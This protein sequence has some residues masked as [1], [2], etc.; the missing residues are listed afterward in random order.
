M[1]QEI[2]NPA[3]SCITYFLMYL[4]Q[5]WINDNFS[6][7]VPKIK[8][9]RYY[10]VVS[11]CRAN[12][13]KTCYTLILVLSYLIESGLLLWEIVSYRLEQILGFVFIYLL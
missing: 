9:K 2:I 7:P 11:M 4:I 8:I 6:T 3:K 13:D 10:I 5:T 1:S 12:K